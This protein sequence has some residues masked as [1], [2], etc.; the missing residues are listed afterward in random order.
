MR[1]AVSC[2]PV[3]DVSGPP[4][5]LEL[6]DDASASAMLDPLDPEG[7]Q[8]WL[9]D[10]M[11]PHHTWGV[12]DYLEKRENLL[13]YFPQM[14]VEMRCYHLGLDIIVPVGTPIHA[15]IAGKVVES[16]YEPGN[17]NY[18][19][20]LILEHRLPGAL[21][22]YSLYGHLN[23][24]RT[25]SQGT[26]VSAGEPVGRTG[27]FECNGRWFHHT[28]MQVITQK[29]MDTGYNRQG[30]CG[31]ELLPSIQ[32]LCPDPVPLFLAGLLSRQWH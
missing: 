10:Q 26:V 8:A 20:Y 21:P 30:Y 27:S 12:C 23:P 9:D 7:F 11:H 1:N 15:P 4:Y 3:V 19:G 14:V 24:E 17:G 2:R 28:H 5:H 22:F 13:R 29:G 16:G 18:G 6:S 32:S 25:V 31:A